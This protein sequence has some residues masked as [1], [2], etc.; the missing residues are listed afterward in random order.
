MEFRVLGVLEALDAGLPVSLGGPKQRS[1]LAML[2]LD[3]NRSVSTDRLVDGLWGDE[4]PQRAAATLQVYVSNLRKALEPDRSPR[5]EPTVLLTQAPGYVLA[6]DPEQVDLFR[7]ERLVSVARS[8]ASHG[9]VAGAAVLFREALALWREAPLAD[10]ANEPFA[11][12]EVPRLEE[13][14]IGAIEDRIDAELALGR[15]VDVAELEGLV[16]RYPYRERLRRHLMVALYRSG[17]QVDAL[18]VYQAARHVL[19]EELG[20]EPGRELREIEAAILVQDPE[21]VP[22]QPAPL[23]AEDVALVLQAANGVDPDPSVVELIVAEACDAPRRAEEALR[24]A[25]EREQSG[26][27]SST[28]AAAGA[29]Q[30][31]LARARRVVADTVLDRR[32]RREPIAAVGGCP[33]KGLLRFEPEDA[34]WYFGRERLVADLLA[35]VASARCT[36]VV[37]ASGSGKSSLA[38]AGLLAALA[39][40]ALPGSAQWPRVLVTPGADPMLELARVLAP[41]CHAPS[42]DH[43]RYRLLDDPESFAGF[44]ARAMNGAT[45]DGALMIVVDQLEEVFTVCRDDSVRDRFFDVLVHAANA[46]D[47]PSRVLVAVRS[48]YYARC[49]EHAAFAELLGRANV[50]VGPMRPDE[51]Q[52]AIEEPARRAGLVLEDGLVERIFDDVGTEPGSL[53]LLETAL[54][55]TW[56]RRNGTTL[57]LEGY[58]SAGGVHGA[59]AHLADDVYARLAPSEQDVARG[60]FLRLAEPGVGTDDVRRRAPLD[61]LVVDDEHAAVLT[62]LVDHRLV[63][64]N[65]AT[66]E[67]AHEALL[68]EWPRLRGWLEA[69]R[70]GRR[71]RRALANGAQEWAAGARDNDLLFR[72]SRLGAALDVAGAHPTEV[73]PVERD[74]LTASRAREE[75][76]LHSARRTAT[77]FRRLTV[78]LAA[79]LVVAVVAGALSLVERSRAD[80]SAARA[81]KQAVASSA[82]SLATQARSLIGEDPDLALLLAVEARR[83]HPA[84][85]T[86][87]AVETALVTG[88]AGVEAAITLEPRAQ[89]YANLSPDGRLVAVAGVDG[90]V[91]LLDVDTGRVLRRLSGPQIIAP[92]APMFNRDGTL[93]AVGSDEGKIRVWNVATGRQVVRPLATQGGGSAY[94]VFDPAHEQQL[95]TAGYDGTVSR[96]DLRAPTP[97]PAD[98]FTVGP[99]TTQYPLVFMFSPDGKRLIVGDPGV[100]PTSAWDVDSRTMLSLVPGSPDSFG[101]DGETFVTS[102]DGLVKVWNVLTGALVS[103]SGSSFTIDPGSIVALERGREVGCRPGSAHAAGPCDRPRDGRGRDPTHFA[104]EERLDPTVPAR[105][106][107]VHR[108]R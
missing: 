58:E 27:L 2:L 16:G 40:D 41:I 83:L 23:V 95:L 12:F 73:N 50:L 43:V 37:G 25:I 65:D 11:T 24:R 67:V 108:Q 47:S 21:L 94:G 77:R 44:A 45:G 3:A 46:P 93:L 66:A 34:G 20:I 62:D 69:D 89:P 18:A 74:F 63:V 29:T 15:D 98:L 33:Y 91:R 28:V 57:T 31:E 84:V 86:D 13:A 96:W 70:E 59:V 101:A 105:R 104:A 103:A 14:R 97:R 72:G 85:D 75:S 32:R 35:T 39:D 42:T 55:E 71:V 92:V 1:V 17:R 106:T 51:L 6:V 19:V 52:R 56:N 10:L 9:C 102:D 5:A 49:A 61:E 64:T 80:D 8:L 88:L 100:G 79:L 38:R 82:S 53:P 99:A 60:I 87:G 54:L 90:F 107:P 78:A 4:P 26:R 68:R 22:D 30:V 81:E 36:G 48:D 76:E 7:F